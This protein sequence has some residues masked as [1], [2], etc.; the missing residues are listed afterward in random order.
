MP[1]RSVDAPARVHRGRELHEFEREIGAALEPGWIWSGSNTSTTH[2]STNLLDVRVPIL[3]RVPGVAPAR[4]A[5]PVG[6]ADIAP[7]LAELLHIPPT[8]PLDGRPLV[9]VVGVP[10]LP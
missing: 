8:E 7:T 5:R 3:F 1:R 10:R 4:V 6:V 2:G 9:E